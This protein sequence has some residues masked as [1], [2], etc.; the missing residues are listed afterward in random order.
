MGKKHRCC[1]PPGA[2]DELITRLEKL[3]RQQAA[4]DG[5]IRAFNV[6]LEAGDGDNM[7]R[8]AAANEE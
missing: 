5:A 7:S 8:Q 4:L 2:L 1:L 6:V 3:E